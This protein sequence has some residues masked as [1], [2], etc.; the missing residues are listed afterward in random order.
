LA[1]A[2]EIV[3]APA[4]KIHDPVF[5]RELTNFIPCGWELRLGL[6]HPSAEDCDRAFI[7]EDETERGVKA[8]EPCL[9]AAC[10]PSSQGLGVAPTDGTAIPESRWR[11]L[12]DA[13]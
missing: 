6:T 7:D 13:V 4:T 8:L 3:D 10:E 9:W 11:Q 1:L 2:P 12:R 5:Q